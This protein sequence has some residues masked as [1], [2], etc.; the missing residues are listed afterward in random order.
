MK[1]KYKIE[2]FKSNKFP[3]G[4]YFVAQKLYFNLFY[5]PLLSFRYGRSLEISFYFIYVQIN[6]PYY[7]HS[8][9]ESA[10]G[11]I[12]RNQ[13]FDV[14]DFCHSKLIKDEWGILCPN[15]ECEWKPEIENYEE[16]KR[17]QGI[18]EF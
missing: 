5:L 18:E 2:E 17:D 3:S 15:E 10:Q 7:I 4:R 11:L 13:G 9:R 14:C 16:T 8:Y 1:P 6:F 12:Y